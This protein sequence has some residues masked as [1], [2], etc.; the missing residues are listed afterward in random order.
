MAYI[1]DS[2]V[3]TSVIIGTSVIIC[4][5]KHGVTVIV[6]PVAWRVYY[7]YLFILSLLLL[8]LSLSLLSWCSY[9]F[10]IIFIIII[11]IHVVV[12]SV[13]EGAGERRGVMLLQGGG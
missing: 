10:I 9:C 12:V 3:L 5:S 13:W 4:S 1:C 8:V 6:R 11:T 2:L 7:Y